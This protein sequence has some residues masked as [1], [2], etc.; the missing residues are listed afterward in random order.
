M[1]G[2]A[3]SSVLFD[4]LA[5]SSFLQAAP[6]LLA[7]FFFPAR[8]SSVAASISRLRFCE[9]TGA[10]NVVVLTPT[11]LKHMHPFS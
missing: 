10:T 6:P 7:F 11:Q 2:S 8:I 3:D 9:V 1:F 5:F 4:F